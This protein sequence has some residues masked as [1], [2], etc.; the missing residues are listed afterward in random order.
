MKTFQKFYKFKIL[1]TGCQILLENLFP[2]A[3]AFKKA[4][5]KRN[6]SGLKNNEILQNADNFQRI[7]L[8]AF[9]PKLRAILPF[10]SETAGTAPIAKF[11]KI[12]IM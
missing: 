11:K 6:N 1:L 5:E 7:L 12:C 10:L 3:A 9:F 4:R 8:R 2:F